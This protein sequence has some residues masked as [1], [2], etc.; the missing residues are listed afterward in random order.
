MT[1]WLELLPTMWYLIW[2]P[3]HVPAASLPVLLPANGLG[4]AVP[5]DPNAWAPA[6]HVVD[7][8]ENPGSGFGLVQHWPLGPSGK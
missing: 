7:L 8:E 3:A 6:M 1:W 5:S 2:V 4:K